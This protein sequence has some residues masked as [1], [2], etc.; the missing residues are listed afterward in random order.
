MAEK[1]YPRLNHIREVSRAVAVAVIRVAFEKGLAGSA[2]P[3]DLDAYV[4]SLMYE[5][6]YRSYV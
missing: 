4:R 6:E 2:V 5:P 1:N 3:V